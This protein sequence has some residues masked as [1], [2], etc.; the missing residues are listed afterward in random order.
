MGA[1]DKMTVK[2]LKEELTKRGLPA[3]GLKAALVARLNEADAASAPTESAPAPVAAAPAPVA[4][5]VGRPSPDHPPEAA[6]ELDLDLD[7]DRELNPSRRGSGPVGGSGSGSG[8][9]LCSASGV[10]LGVGLGL[11]LGPVAGFSPPGHV[12]PPY[13][14]PPPRIRTVSNTDPY[15]VRIRSVYG[16]ARRASAPYLRFEGSSSGQSRRRL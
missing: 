6:L 1:Y 15:K 14:H 7:L 2:D 3:S 13:T 11:G 12:S 16:P 5:P 10:S 8:L 4:A 9:G